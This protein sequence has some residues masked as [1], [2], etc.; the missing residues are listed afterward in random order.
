[1]NQCLIN[2]ISPKSIERICGKPMPLELSSGDE[3]EVATDVD[4]RP[5]KG[6]Q[7][8]GQL[9]RSESLLTHHVCLLTADFK[10]FS[11]PTLFGGGGSSSNLDPTPVTVTSFSTSFP[12]AACPFTRPDIDAPY[13]IP[14]N[15]NEDDIET[16]EDWVIDQQLDELEQVQPSKFSEAIAKEVCVCI[17]MFSKFTAIVQ[18]PVWDDPLSADDPSGFDQITSGSYLGSGNVDMSQASNAMFTSS[19]N[20]PRLPGKQFHQQHQPTYVNWLQIWPYRW[21]RNWQRQMQRQ[22]Q[23]RHRHQP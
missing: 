2:L 18:R 19:V 8:Q 21:H 17:S 6:K 4:N 10:L 20:T 3:T 12:P 5:A 15:N 1:V 23:H 7:R 14:A 22:C 9:R 13:S 11:A 16:E